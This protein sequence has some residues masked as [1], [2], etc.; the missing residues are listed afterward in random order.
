MAGIIKGSRDYA[1]VGSWNAVCDRCGFKYKAGELRKE[2]DGLMVCD[3][4]WEPR[5]PQDL[6]RPLPDPEP[7]PWSRPKPPP[8]NVN[9]GFQFSRSFNG[10]QINYNSF[11]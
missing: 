4:C 6:V 1:L 9:P 5:N 10:M 7:V 8:N 11:D 2:W 3:K